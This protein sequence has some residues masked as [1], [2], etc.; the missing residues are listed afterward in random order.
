MGLLDLPGSHLEQIF[1][2]LLMLLE[3]MFEGFHVVVDFLCKFI[4]IIQLRL[5]GF[6]ESMSMMRYQGQLLFDLEYPIQDRVL[7]I[8]DLSFLHLRYSL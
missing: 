4:Q 6:H 5:L 7:A 3:G 1:L 2:G 8:D